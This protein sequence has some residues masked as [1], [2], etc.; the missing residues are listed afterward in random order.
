[1]KKVQVNEEEIG[2]SGFPVDADA[3]AA[4]PLL[5]RAVPAEAHDDPDIVREAW[6]KNRTIVTSN[7]SRGPGQSPRR[8]PGRLNC[9]RRGR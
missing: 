3:K 7:P 6:E 5:D 4:I 1:M 2:W 9:G 8:G